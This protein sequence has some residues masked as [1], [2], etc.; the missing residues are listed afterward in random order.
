MRNLAVGEAFAVA[1]AVASD[2]AAELGPVDLAGFPVSALLVELQLM[3]W[4]GCFPPT[5]LAFEG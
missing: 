5:G 3:G 1:R 2:D 4:T